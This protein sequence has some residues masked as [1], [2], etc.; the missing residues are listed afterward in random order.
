MRRQARGAR[1]QGPGE[2]QQTLPCGTRPGLLCAVRHAVL[3][4]L[5]CLCPLLC[6]AFLHSACLS[7]LPPPP[8]FPLSPSL[9]PW[10][11]HGSAGGVLP[12]A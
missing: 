1:L 3:G 10:W 2:G 7:I 4:I 6:P 5:S 11:M 8:H 12:R 9:C